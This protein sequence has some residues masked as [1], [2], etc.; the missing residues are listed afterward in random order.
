MF[1]AA[2]QHY[3]K[4]MR[5]ARKKMAQKNLSRANIVRIPVE[6]SRDFDIC[7]IKNISHTSLDFT[8]LYLKQ[9][10]YANILSVKVR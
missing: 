1:N 3:D 2:T 10:V 4:S 8:Y 6:S 7:A 9:I 5:L